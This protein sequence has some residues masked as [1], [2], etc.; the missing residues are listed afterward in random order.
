MK[1]KKRLLEVY[2]KAKGDFHYSFEE[3]LEDA[4][5]FIKDV[6]KR[7][8]ICSIKVSSSGMSRRFDFKDYNLLL[9]V[10]YNQKKEYDCVKVSGCGMDMHWNLKYITC[11]DLMTKKEIEKYNI[12]MLCSSGNIL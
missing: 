2:N 12:N 9:N 4:K 11:Q 1:S 3:F 7:N 10:C 5:S 8:T 6:K